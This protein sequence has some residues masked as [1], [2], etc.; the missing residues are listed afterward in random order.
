MSESLYQAWLISRDGDTKIGPPTPSRELAWQE[1]H[2][3]ATICWPTS[4]ELRRLFES[5]C[6]IGIVVPIGGLAASPA[7]RATAAGDAT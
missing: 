6:R 5:R 4:P 3:E 2:T 7:T 1:V